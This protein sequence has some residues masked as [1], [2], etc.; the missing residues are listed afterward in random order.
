MLPEVFTVCYDISI[1]KG[2]PAAFLV[3]F[4]ML[5]DVCG[6]NQKDSA[7]AVI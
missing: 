7:H 6:T 5:V 2:F 1:R 3:L 4:H